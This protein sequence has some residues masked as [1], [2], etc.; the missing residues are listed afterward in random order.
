MVKLVALRDIQAG[1]EICISYLEDCFLERSRHTR[2]KELRENY[3][4]VCSCPKCV[5]QKD[6]PDVS[7]EEEEDDDDDAND[8]DEDWNTTSIRIKSISYYISN[9]N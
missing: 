9:N 5:D 1:E 6:D 3:L 4:F 8:M 2:Q 7:S